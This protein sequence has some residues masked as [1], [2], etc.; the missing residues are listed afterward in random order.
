MSKFIQWLIVALVLSL[1]LGGPAAFADV[2]GPAAMTF[3]DGADAF[4]E[5]QAD[6]LTTLVNA[7]DTNK[8]IQQQPEPQPAAGAVQDKELSAPGTQ[9]RINGWGEKRI[10]AMG[11][12]HAPPG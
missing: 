2:D 7:S 3:D 4:A 1:S 5:S 10:L 8:L 9:V 6:A 12:T 11:L